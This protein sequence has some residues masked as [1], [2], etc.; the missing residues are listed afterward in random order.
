LEQFRGQL[1]ASFRF[2][3]LV[4]TDRGPGDCVTIQQLARLACVLASDQIRFFQNAH[5]AEGDVFQVANGRGD[6]IE[7][8][9]QR[10]SSSQGG[11]GRLTN[12]MRSME[13]APGRRTGICSR[14]SGTGARSNGMAQ[15]VVA[16]KL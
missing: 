3:V 7:R 1:R 12:G 10:F 5:G 14:L 15:T 2:V 6:Q 4:V 13:S 16:S 8:A 9:A 11:A